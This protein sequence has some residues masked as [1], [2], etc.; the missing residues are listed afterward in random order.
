VGLAW[1]DVRRLLDSDFGEKSSNLR[2]AA[3]LSLCAIYGFRASE[4]TKLTLDDFD[5]INETVAVRRAKNGRV[6]QFPLQFEVGKPFCDT[7]ALDGQFVRV[8]DCLSQ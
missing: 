1:S 5:W 8:E 7:F 2:A 6:Q 3:I 4:I